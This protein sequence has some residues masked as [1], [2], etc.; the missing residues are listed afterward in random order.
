MVASA[1][2][3]I[4][5]NY[6][7][8]IGSQHKKTYKLKHSNNICIFICI[9]RAIYADKADI[10]RG[11]CL[12]MC[13]CVSPTN[14]WSQTDVTS[15]KLF[16][17]L[18]H[19]TLSFDIKTTTTTT[20]FIDSGSQEA[21]LVQDRHSYNKNKQTYKEKVSLKIKRRIWNKRVFVS[22]CTRTN[23]CIFLSWFAYIWGRYRIA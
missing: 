10:V 5:I 1:A 19:T 21:G 18:W 16:G 6:I 22:G 11:V 4:I 20:T 3:I 9:V 7:S 14:D 2:V 17:V 8:P 13:L 15:Y 23:C 12:C